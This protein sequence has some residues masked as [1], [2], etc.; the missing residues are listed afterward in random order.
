MESPAIQCSIRK[1]AEGWRCPNAAIHIIT[2]PPPQRPSR[3]YNGV[4]GW[5]S[6]VCDDHVGV[7][8]KAA[9]GR[10]SSYQADPVGTPFWWEQSAAASAAK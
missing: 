1:F 3:D 6:Y 7:Y 10:G 2:A 9:G 5:K 4:P 8:T